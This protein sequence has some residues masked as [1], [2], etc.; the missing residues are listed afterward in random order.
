MPTLTLKTYQQSALAALML[1]LRQAGT[2]G[3]EAAWAHA[4]ARDGAGQAGNKA[5]APYR[6]DELGDVPCVCLRIPTGGGKTL[7]AS[8]AIPLIAQAWTHR[9]FP[10]ALWL[11]P[12]DTIRSQTLNARQ[13]SG[14]PYREALE[15]SYGAGVRACVLDDPVQADLNDSGEEFLCAQLP[16]NHRA[17]KH[18]VR[19]LTTAPYGIALAT[20]KGRFYPDFVAELLDGRVA[21]VKYKGAHLLSDPYEIEK[22]HI[23]E[24]W[25]RK[26]AGKCLFGQIVKDQACVGMSGQL[27]TLLA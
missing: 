11:V 2:M 6:A 12:S 25:A 10:V 9:D 3:L 19:N 20:S 17:V 1:F 7:M 18:W 26:I 13:T 15:G 14:H 8:H 16:D 22:R 5:G 4:M 23:G 24:L 21:V 27:D